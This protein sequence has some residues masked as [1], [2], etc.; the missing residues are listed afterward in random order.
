MRFRAVLVVCAFSLP[1]MADEG[2]WLFN[3]FPKEQV[4]QKYSVDV[5][6]SF[7][8][9]LRL[10]S[11]RVGGGSGSF[12][13]PGGLIFSNHHIVAECLSK[14]GPPGRDYLKDGFYAAAQSDETNC[15]GLE[16]DVL[17]SVSDVTRQ[18]KDEAKP[19]AKAAE[20][21]QKRNAAAAAIEKD[22]REKTRH[23]CTVVKL[24]SG[25]RYDLYQYRQFT[26]LRLVFAPE[27]GIAFF[28]G[29]AEHSTY[30]RYDLDIAFLRAYENGKPADTPDYLK[31]SR[32]GVKDTDLVFAAGNPGAT[33]RLATAAQL[34][35]YRDTS[36]PL[37]LVRLQTRIEALRIFAAKSPEN[38]RAA[39]RL[40]SDF[41]NAYKSN[42]GRL[43]GLKEDRL[44]PR[45]QNFERKL[46]SAVEHDPKLGTEAGKVW[47]EVAA[48]YKNWTPFEK[49]FEIL[50]RPAAQGSTLFRIARQIVRLSEERSKPNEQRLP[51]FR[52]S[53]LTSL[54]L[55]L[56]SPAPI[57]ESLEVAMV[58]HYLEELKALGDKE[59]PVK[60]VLGSRTP[61]QAA[62]EFVRT[63]KLKEVAERKRL[64]ADHNLVLK[65]D[66]GMI[67]LARLLEEPA[68]KLLK[69]H[70]DT[71]ESLEASSSE[72]IAQ[73]RFKVFGVNDYPDA[74]FTPRVTFGTVKAYRD[75][76]EAPVPFATT[77]GGLY[78]LAGLLEPYRLP[79]RWID[80]KSSLDM[81]TPFNFVS[82]C[83]SAGGNSGNPAVN[84]KGEIVG[85]SFDGNIE[86]L[87]LTYLYSDEQARAV[88]AATQG[89]V[90]VLRKLYKTPQL[91]RELGVPA[92]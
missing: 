27:L 71:I 79:R 12:V 43:I 89:I 51:E 81:V 76:T 47:D 87:A 90:E 9:H 1:L 29:D 6:D 85:I 80:G 42:A 56:Y 88:H 54:E 69:K 48:A 53:A 66:D 74:T 18:V 37:T 45:K 39:E 55:S 86:S 14:I 65:S 11:L 7:L 5:S 82:T 77:F 75:K 84:Q 49:P 22:C 41:G 72:R 58:T 50:E 30:Q 24:F 67:R 59:A 13:S 35:F 62:E 83:D 46:R 10:A 38:R 34:A 57:D 63:S 92:T 31:W 20:V 26:D 25:E 40:L 15:P 19:G 4:K 44:M 70:E 16:A 52:D 8:E 23:H 60:A 91:L 33:S 3:Q 28:G 73:Y 36:L 21:L 17:L 64:A 2:M 78:H 32:E 61:Q 68:R